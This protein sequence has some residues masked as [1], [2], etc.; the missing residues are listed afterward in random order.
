MPL[1]NEICF[2]TLF[3]L[4]GAK[5]IPKCKPRFGVVIFA[6]IATTFFPRLDKADERLETRV[7]LP[8]PP[9]PDVQTITLVI[10]N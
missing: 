4:F 9:L 1:R 10:I 3:K 2:K 8:T 7:V 5:C 6:S